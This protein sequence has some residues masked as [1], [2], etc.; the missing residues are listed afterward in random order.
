[1]TTR[2]ELAANNDD[3]CQVASGPL[4]GMTALTGRQAAYSQCMQ[5]RYAAGSAG[6]RPEDSY[7]PGQSS[8][9]SAI[10]Q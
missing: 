8:S 3:N 6:F 1:M 5:E 7:A 9:L 2:A 4:S 10:G